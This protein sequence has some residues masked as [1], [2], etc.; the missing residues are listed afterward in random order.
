[1]KTQIDSDGFVY[2]PDTE[3]TAFSGVSAGATVRNANAGPPWIVVNHSSAAVLV[4]RWPGRLFRVAVLEK[5]KEQPMPSA[6]YTRAVAVL[7]VEE[8]PAITLLGEQGAPLAAILERICTLSL[9]DA[10]ALSAAIQPS[11]SEI[12]STAWKNWL[13]KVDGNSVYLDEDH[14]DTLQVRVGNAISPVGYALS[15]ISSMV[16]NQGRA[17]SGPAA[18]AVD[19]EGEVEL[20]APWSGASTALLH[21][22]MA[23]GAPGLLTQ[24]QAAVLKLPWE[25]IMREPLDQ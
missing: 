13:A 2:V 8:L 14:E 1:M 12:F 15:L 18:I 16:F 11:S 7:V 25:A 3:A 10:L 20:Q 17:V 6:S 4:A 24:P 9:D 22:A 21:A 5:A 23:F 19:A